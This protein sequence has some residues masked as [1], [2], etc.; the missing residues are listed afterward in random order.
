MSLTEF[1]PTVIL[2]ILH[3]GLGVILKSIA[4]LLLAVTYGY[5]TIVPPSEGIA[6]AEM[7]YSRRA[8]T[9]KTEI[10]E[11][12]NRSESSRQYFRQ[13]LSCLLSI[14]NSVIDKLLLYF[15]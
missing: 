6:V 1:E 13:I 12:T 3:P 8:K 9:G 5:G 15:L 2:P 14:Y 10:A 11:I 7:L 4:S